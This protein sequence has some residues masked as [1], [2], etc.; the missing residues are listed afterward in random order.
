MAS[1]KHT[2]AHSTTVRSRWLLFVVVTS[3]LWL[4]LLVRMIDLQLVRGSSFRAQAEDNRFFTV[5]VAAD[6]GVISDRFGASLAWNQRQYFKI[7][8]THALYSSTSLLDAAEARQLMATDSAAVSLASVRE[9][10]F[11]EALAHV[12]GYLG[13]VTADDLARS[14]DLK[15]RHVVG[16]IGLEQLFDAQLRGIDG[17]EQYE[18]NAL[19]ERQRKVATQ[20]SKP[21]EGLQTTLDPYLS[22][23]A[24]RALGEQRGSVVIQDAATGEVLTLVNAPSFNPT[25]LSKPLH[26]A[27]A[28]QARQDYI[29]NLF[30]DETKPFFNRAVAGEYPPG[31]VYKLVTAL[32]GLESGAFDTTTTVV[33]EGV[34]KV[35][36]YEYG[37]WY[38]RQFGRTEG[39]IGVVRSLARSNDI[40]F[41]KA[42]EWTGVDALVEMSKLMGLGEVTGI[43]FASQS[44]GLVPT[45]AWKEEVQGERWFL[46]N[47]YH[48]GIG[49]GDVL[50]SPIQVSQMVQ[51]LANNGQRCTPTLLSGSRVECQSLSLSEEH[52]DTVLRGMLDACSPTGTAYPFFARNEVRREEG[53]SVTQDLG[54]GAVACKTGTAEFGGADSRGYRNTHGWWVGIVE[55]RLDGSNIGVDRYPIPEEI[56]EQLPD[57]G[58]WLESVEELGYPQRLVITVLVESD[59]ENPFKEGSADAGSVGKIILDWV[60]GNVE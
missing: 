14:S 51:T 46:G 59:E 31:S 32:A 17:S 45:P 13:A 47:T 11:P 29:R 49:Q 2:T 60:E 20:Q 24:F 21:G 53:T 28:E 5:P 44:D 35:G 16:R 38:F 3:V 10:L 50:V 15:A 23:V 55:P 37:N 54:R 27:Q 42:A 36:E 9:H 34:L 18:I 41:Y 48:M 22:E 33:D 7:D 26:D 8:D 1:T 43:E 56:V 4:L 58:T 12:V 19:V 52:I 40:Y 30:S 57:R 39:E 25:L 6:R